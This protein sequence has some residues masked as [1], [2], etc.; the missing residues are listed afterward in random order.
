MVCRI[1]N[2]Q[3]KW[4]KESSEWSVCK[5]KWDQSDPANGTCSKHRPRFSFLT[6]SRARQKLSEFDYNAKQSNWIGGVLKETFCCFFSEC[7]AIYA[8]GFIIIICWNNWCYHNVLSSTWLRQLHHQ[9]Q[10]KINQTKLYLPFFRSFSCV[11][12]FSTDVA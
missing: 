5:Q 12:F 9:Q 10:H 6:V 1:Y 2:N 3:F 7:K 4:K 8:C 11:W